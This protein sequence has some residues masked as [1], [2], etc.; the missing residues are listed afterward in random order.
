MSV[1]FF[2]CHNCGATVCECGPYIS[3]ESCGRSWYDRECAEYEGF[4]IDGGDNPFSTC[5]FCRGEA[6]EDIELLNYILM[7]EEITRAQLVGSL[8]QYKQR[9]KP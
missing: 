9:A 5:S 6:F 8:I 3:C 7:R 2:E 4:K 1:D